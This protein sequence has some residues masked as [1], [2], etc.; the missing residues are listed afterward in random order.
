VRPLTA[1]EGAQAF[2]VDELEIEAP[3]LQQQYSEEIADA[4]KGALTDSE[5]MDSYNLPAKA[6]VPL[7]KVL[8]RA[9]RDARLNQRLASLYAAAHRFAD[10][11]RCCE[12]LESL[13]RA[14]GHADMASQYHD[15]AAKYRDR[16][17]AAVVSAVPEPAAP[18]KAAPAPVSEPPQVSAPPEAAAVAAEIDL[19]AEWESETAEE[20]PEVEVVAEEPSTA[21]I[22]DEVRFYISQSMWTEAQAACRRC[23][24]AAPEHPDLPALKAQIAAALTPPAPEIPAAEI[25]APEIKVTPPPAPPVQAP[26]IIEPVPVAS[27]ARPAGKN[28]DVLDDF[29][30]DLEA[31]LGADFTVA[32]PTAAPAPKP[33][34]VAVPVAS[35]APQPVVA[36]PQPVVVAAGSIAVASSPA[37]QAAA[38]AA[39]PHVA[40]SQDE[41]SSALADMFA[42]FKSEAEDGTQDTEDPETHYNLGVAFREMGLLDEA[43]GELQKVCL[44]IDQGIAFPQTMQAYTWLAQCF[45]EKGVP[46]AS[47]KWYDKALKV[48]S[49]E[50]QRMALHYDMAAAYEAG[51]NRQAALQHFMEVYGSNIDYRDVAER[52]KVLR[53]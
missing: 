48:A 42:E 43:I 30:S 44:A 5:L 1:E 4:I 10:A 20:P 11:V 26:P 27:A 33:A 31:S 35:I 13:Y 14:A 8:P 38:T 36:S 24:S 7:E 49:Q 6:L 18:P 9:P 40:P 39:E 23:E 32:P 51:G 17:P 50:E 19:S 47:V 15:I 41:A 52:I 22:L 21:D 25:P 46:E 37:M 2:M 16:I 3:A 12:V 53:S 34:P 45:V 29:V 28:G